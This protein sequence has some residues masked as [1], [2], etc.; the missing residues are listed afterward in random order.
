ML[1]FFVLSV[2]CVSSNAV[3]YDEDEGWLLN[4]VGVYGGYFIYIMSD[5]L[6][7]AIDFNELVIWIPVNYIDYFSS[8]DNA[9]VNISSSS[10]TLRA[11]DIE[12]NVHT[13][14]APAYSYFQIRTDHTPYTYYDLTSMEVIDTNVPI[15]G[16]NSPFF[17][18]NPAWD[19]NTKYICFAIGLSAMALILVGVFNGKRNG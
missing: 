18:A 14:R 12:H 19:D 7:N 8:D 5:D 11:Y 10:L 13:I 4:Y 1:V 16:E 9:L 3:F 6:Y 15:K 17:N 2:T